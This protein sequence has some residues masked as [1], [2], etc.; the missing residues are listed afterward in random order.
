MSSPCEYGSFGSSCRM[1]LCQTFDVASNKRVPATS[2]RILLRIP[3]HQFLKDINVGSSV[4][5][6]TTLPTFVGEASPACQQLHFVAPLTG[7]SR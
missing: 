6:G 4:D 7:S 5:I 1:A 2:P 3:G